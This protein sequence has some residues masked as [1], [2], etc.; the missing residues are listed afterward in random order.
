[1][2]QE[3]PLKRKGPE[4]CTTELEM[5]LMDGYYVGYYVGL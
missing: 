3:L 2:E 5:I 4:A 1:V